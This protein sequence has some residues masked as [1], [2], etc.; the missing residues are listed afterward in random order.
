M[1]VCNSHLPPAIL[2]LPSLPSLYLY[3]VL[4]MHG[5]GWD[6]QVSGRVEANSHP[7]T[8]KPTH[9]QLLGLDNFAEKNDAW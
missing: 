2:L 1:V 7:L 3:E 6:M 9:V 5:A 4:Y 8:H